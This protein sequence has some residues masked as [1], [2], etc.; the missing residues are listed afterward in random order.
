MKERYLYKVSITIIHK[1]NLTF[2]KRFIVNTYS[3]NDA[4]EFVINSLTRDCF[5]VSN[6][7]AFNEIIATKLV[8]QVGIVLSY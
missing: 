8:L 3:A 1:T 4:I 7:Y 5:T 2:R 6:G